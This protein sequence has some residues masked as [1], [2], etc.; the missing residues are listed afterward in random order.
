MVPP[1]QGASWAPPVQ[2]IDKFMYRFNGV[3][4][5]PNGYF[6][7]F[8]VP[9]AGGTPRQLT[10]GAAHHTLFY[11]AAGDSR[12]SAPIW[13]PDGNSLL[14]VANLRADYEY[15][16]REYE[17]HELSVATGDVTA[18][19]RRVG[20]DYDP[21]IS[22]DGRHIAYVGYDD[23]RL[24]Y[25]V[26]RLYVMNRDGTESRSLTAGFD[27]AVQRPKWSADGGGIY[28]VFV[29]EG[30][31]HLAHI[32]L[33]GRMR[34]LADD[35]GTIAPYALSAYSWGSD[36]SIAAN[37]RYAVTHA[38]TDRGGDIATGVST[39]N[40]TTAV[41]DVNGDIIG[42]KSLGEIE[43]LRY[44]SAA[45]G[46][47]IRGWVIKPPH[48]QPSKRYPL[49]LAFKGGISAYGNKFDLQLR[50]LAAKG[51]VVSY[52]NQRGSTS[53]G[54]R[55]ANMAHDNFPGQ[56]YVD[57]MS[58]LDELV[59]RPYIDAR[60]VY[61]TGPSLGGQMTLW[62]IGKT[63]RF[64]A[65]VAVMP[66]VNRY[67]SV[68]TADHTPI[69]TDYRFK[70]LPWERP[71]HYLDMS[72]IS[73]VGAVSTPTM[74]I[75]GEEDYRTPISESEQYYK[76]LKLRRVDAVLVR[77][78]G[79]PHALFFRSLSHQYATLLNTICWFEKYR[80]RD[81]IGEAPDPRCR[82]DNETPGR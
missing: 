19:T 76:A 35:L 57:V 58:G 32:D 27:Y 9:S 73:L 60:N 7:I 22:P 81:A 36:Y 49:I 61:A 14:F 54:E 75:T 4:Y 47:P 51:Y 6:Q 40:G 25:Q 74:I 17:I 11:H 59:K 3:G 65:A 18:L 5:L 53:F 28:F 79:E 70:G 26:S 80:T 45:D 41:T 48:F 33:Q 82:D 31:C 50:I 37:G 55:F 42:N 2:V 78:P 13:S 16:P 21:A 77:V 64:A 63:H 72:P 20:P 10:R 62:V 46:L 34:I 66:V 43:E 39:R 24:A 15:Q 68:L 30:I 44:R 71:Q 69:Y 56:A 67:S 1:P 52:V 8:V 23:R 29:K 12:R 38:G